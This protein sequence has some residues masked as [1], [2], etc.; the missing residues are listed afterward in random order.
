M[1]K[2]RNSSTA[3]AV[4][5]LLVG[6]IGLITIGCLSEN[7]SGSGTVEN[8]TIRMEDPGHIHTWHEASITFIVESSQTED[9]HA[10]NLDSIIELFSTKEAYAVGDHGDEG[11]GQDGGGHDE[12]GGEQPDGPMTGLNFH[13][14]YQHQGAD[15]PSEASVMEGDITDNG[16]GTYTWTRTFVESGVYV[17]TPFFESGGHMFSSSFPIEVSKAGG[18]RIYSPSG[19]EATESCAYNYQIRWENSPGHIHANGEEITFNIEIKRSYGALNYDMPFR[20]SFDHLV[21]PASSSNL[22]IEPDITIQGADFI[23]PS[24]NYIGLGVWEA[25]AVFNQ[26]GDYELHVSFEDP[27][28]FEIH[29]HGGEDY[30]FHVS[31]VH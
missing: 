20:N 30:A 2:N 7:S 8:A 12:G 17:I 28:G 29:E 18:E 25:K 27:D 22:W 26:S 10:N 14:S 31:D 1:M 16:D 4:I 24:V 5:F 13:I 19:C 21:G 3:F 9:T 23:E 6:V 11:G 15:S